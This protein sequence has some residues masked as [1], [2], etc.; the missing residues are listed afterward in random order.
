MKVKSENNFES[1]FNKKHFILP[2][3]LWIA[4]GLLP[5]PKHLRRKHTPNSLRKIY[6][7]LLI[8]AISYVIIVVLKER[9]TRSAEH[10][11]HIV[12]YM[13][14]LSATFLNLYIILSINLWKCVQYE[15][16][17]AKFTTID[18]IIH[19]YILKS[20]KFKLKFFAGVSVFNI[21]L[22]LFSLIVQLV[23][24]N[25][26]RL[27]LESTLRYHT[28]FEIFM[29]KYY[30]DQIGW[31]YDAIRNVMKQAI[32]KKFDDKH[33]VNSFGDMSSCLVLLHDIIDIFNSIFGKFLLIFTLTV[34]LNL[35]VYIE[36]SLRHFNRRVDSS[37]VLLSF[38]LLE[39]VSLM[40]KLVLMC[41]HFCLWFYAFN[42][43][44]FL[45]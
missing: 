14:L 39:L 9:F 35:I 40:S 28:F 5:W 2:L 42:F 32:V 30:I 31:R 27:N 16:L 11:R 34:V 8:T 20:S 29:L 21:A 13:F 43:Y 12:K 15:E 4:L 23:V 41:N 24:R 45:F 18:N 44:C 3:L 6:I 25:Q 38:T 7:T 17:L 26:L 22:P 37:I 33:G 10:S 36:S 19:Q 1:K